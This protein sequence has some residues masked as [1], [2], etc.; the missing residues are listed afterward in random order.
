VPFSPAS[1]HHT[2]LTRSKYFPDH[3][4]ICVSGRRQNI[5]IGDTEVGFWRWTEGLA[6]LKG[7]KRRNP[8]M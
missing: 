6:V 5:Q 3:I 1:S 4:L 8:W 7:I 2:I